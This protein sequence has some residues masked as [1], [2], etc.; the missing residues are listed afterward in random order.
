MSIWILLPY[1]KGYN[2]EVHYHLR[3]ANVVADALSRKSHCN[4]HMVESPV[5]NLCAE[6]EGLNLE[7]ATQEQYQT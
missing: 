5:T 3:K 6:M 1:T 7:M 4:C 2:L